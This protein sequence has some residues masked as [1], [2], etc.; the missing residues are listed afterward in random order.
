MT[1]IFNWLKTHKLVL[2]LLVVVIY[3]FNKSSASPFALNQQNFSIPESAVSNKMAVGSASLPIRDVAPAPQVANRMVIKES[4]L[5]LLVNKVTESQ[6][7]I[8]QKVTE[9]GG[10]MVNV[11]VN[12]PQEVASATITVRVPAKNL[13]QTL[14][15]FRSI[16]VKIISENL[17]G[18]DVT[19]QYVDLEKRLETLNKTKVKFEQIMDRTVLVADILEVQREL[20]NLQDQIDSIKGQQQYYEKSAEMSKVIIY[21]ATD[22]LALPYTPTEAWRPQAIFK[23]AVRSL[24]G[25]AR[26]LGTSII[27]I[28]VYAIIWV[29]ALIVVLFVKKRFKQ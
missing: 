26:S 24:V 17:Q 11:S 9:V 21:L 2:L 10:Y 13:D 19:D 6:K 8:L 16:S 15:Y 3:L 1:S 14:E 12:N 18:G 7:K 28:A 22:E 20:I 29:P 27:W 5:S 25:S 23:E 4:N